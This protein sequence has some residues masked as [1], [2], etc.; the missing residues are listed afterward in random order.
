MPGI[1]LHSQPFTEETLAKLRIFENYVQEWLPTFVM[2]EFKQICI[3]DFFA[4]TGYDKVGVPGSPIRILRQIAKNRSILF[5][6]NS[7]IKV[8][9]NEFSKEKFESLE[10]ACRAYVEK[11]ADL[12]ALSKSCKL[13]VFYYNRDFADIFKELLPTIQNDASLVFLDQNGVKFIA[14]DYFIPLANTTKT[15]FLYYVASSYIERFKGTEEFK[16]YITFNFDDV[17]KGTYTFVH[18]YLLSHLQERIPS[19]SKVKLYPF[20]IKKGTNIYGIVFGSSHPRGVDKFLKTAWK[21]NP[22]NGEANFDIYDDQM[23]NVDLFNGIQLN[24]IQRFKNK[25][26]EEL[27]KGNLK[28]NKDVFEFTLKDGHIS[29]HAL[30]LIKDLKKQKRITYAGKSPKVSYENCFGK[31]AELVEFQVIK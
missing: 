6:K 11:D 4:G 7:Q 28:N 18:K 30:E 25:L 12:K 8:F 5:E 22:E 15:D 27:L 9:L 31:N 26:E 2:S 1:D 14:D 17:E 3:F 21:E 19:T 10:S 13:K 29:S 20:S 23:G 16:K 24:K